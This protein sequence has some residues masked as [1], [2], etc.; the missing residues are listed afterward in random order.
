VLVERGCVL[1]AELVEKLRRTL[2][3]GE[4]ERDNTRG[5]ACVH[6]TMMADPR[7]LV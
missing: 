6:E 2:D 3:I 1:V 5:E 7:D 4:E